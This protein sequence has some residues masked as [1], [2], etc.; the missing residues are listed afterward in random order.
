[1][2]L[3][4]GAGGFCRYSLSDIGELGNKNEY[5]GKELKELEKN[6]TVVDRDYEKPL[7]VI[8]AERALCADAR[9]LSFNDETFD[10]VSME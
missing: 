6:I 9:T 1:M 3:D 5:T 10:V 4:V 7:S 2:L 8:F